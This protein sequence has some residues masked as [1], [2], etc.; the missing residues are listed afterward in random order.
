MAYSSAYVWWGDDGNCY[1]QMQ[2]TNVYENLNVWGPDNTPTADLIP[3][4]E[5]HNPSKKGFFGRLF[6]RQVGLS[7]FACKSP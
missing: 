1:F 5:H 3:Y 6:S 4:D 2:E 7:H